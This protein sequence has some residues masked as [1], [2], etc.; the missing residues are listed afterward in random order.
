MTS[1]YWPSPLP[2]A[3]GPLL[4]ADDVRDAVKATIL[5]WSPYYLAVESRRLGT[6]GLIGGKNQS[7]FPLAP[8]GTWINEP[9]FRSVGTGQP[10]AFLVRVLSSEN[11][12]AQGNGRVAATYKTAVTVQVFGTSWEEA[13]DVTSYYEKAVRWCVMQ[14]RSLG[15]LANSTKWL[16]TEYS[17]QEHS[18]SRTE[19]VAVLVFEV[20]LLNTINTLLGP[21]V[22]PA[23]GQLPPDFTA[24]E[25]LLDLTKYPISEGLPE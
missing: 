17:A 7:A 2:D 14:H 23:N 4:G 22:P 1:T 15:G 24:E 13:T 12:D 20:K 5:L 18:S 25:V 6:A 8:F 10:A 21:L 11:D 16:S 19:G 9:D 3:L